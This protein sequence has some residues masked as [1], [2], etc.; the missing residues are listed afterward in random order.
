[1]GSTWVWYKL[2]WAVI[3]TLI[4]PSNRRDAVILEIACATDSS[5]WCKLGAR[6]PSY[7]GNIVQCLVVCHKCNIRCQAYRGSTIQHCM[8]QQQ[9]LLLVEMGILRIRS[10]IYDRNL[11]ITL[12]QQ[13]TETSSCTTTETVVY[14]EPWRPVQLSASLRTRS[15]HKSTTSLPTVWWPQRGYLRIFFAES[16]LVEQRS[17][18]TRANFINCR[19]FQ[20]KEYTTWYEFTS[21]SLTEESSMG[22]IIG[23]I[24]ITAVHAS[25]WLLAIRLDT[26]LKAEKFPASITDLYT[27]LP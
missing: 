12:K 22:I 10:L 4:A 17:V 27:G 11:Q 8:A 19:W 3:S 14:N 21:T 2:V 5:S 1:M 6:C 18:C 26:V 24:C 23:V 25:L 7:D 13:C 9:Q 15:K 20:I 16:V